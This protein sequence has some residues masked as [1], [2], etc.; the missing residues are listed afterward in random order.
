MR[1]LQEHV[2]KDRQP[3]S[4]E[5]AAPMIGPRVGGDDRGAAAAA[6]PADYPAAM[7]E[8]DSTTPT[9]PA[10]SPSVSNSELQQRMI[11]LESKLLLLEH[12]FEALNAAFLDRGEQ[13]VGLSREL[14][15]LSEQVESGGG[16]EEPR[17]LEENKPPHY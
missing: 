6:Q 12:D 1:A 7:P 16:G 8:S 10:A 14:Q 9:D 13:I 15:K 4:G 17:S 11:D 3:A 5:P 2:A